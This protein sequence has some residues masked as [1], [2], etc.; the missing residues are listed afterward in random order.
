[1]SAGRGDMARAHRYERSAARGARSFARSRPRA[2]RR[3]RGP[4]R[5]ARG[6]GTHV[7]KKAARR[8]ARPYAFVTRIQSTSRG[9]VHVS[10]QS[11]SLSA[12]SVRGSHMWG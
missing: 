4:P 6:G 10:I 11:A 5:G 9:R 2:R 1:M 7:S 12:K 3:Q 8:A